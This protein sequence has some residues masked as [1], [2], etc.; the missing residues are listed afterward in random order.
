MEEEGRERQGGG[1]PKRH[2]ESLG[3]SR[4]VPYFDGGEGV[5][6]KYVSKLSNCML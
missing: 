5:M 3:S 6:S 1:S 4:Y 2:E